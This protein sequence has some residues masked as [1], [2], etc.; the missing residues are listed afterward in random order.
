MPGRRSRWMW[1]RDD[2]EIVVEFA[3]VRHV[4]DQCRQDRQLIHELADR[5]FADWDHKTWSQDRDLGSKPGAA[6]RDLLS[7]GNT[8]AP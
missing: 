2:V 3:H 5:Q 4:T 1:Q 6:E 8:I 7:G